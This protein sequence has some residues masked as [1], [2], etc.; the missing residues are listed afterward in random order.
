MLFR[1]RVTLT[2][3]ERPLFKGSPLF[4]S[5]SAEYAQLLRQDS[6]GTQSVDKGL[7]R[8]DVT[9]QLRY[10]FKKWQWFTVN[11]SLAFRETWYSKSQDPTVTDPATNQP[12]LLSTALNRHYFTMT[13]SVVGP[14]FNRIWN[15]PDNGY[16]EKFK[17][18]IEPYTTVM[19]TSDIGDL[20]RIIQIDSTDF[21][22]GG[23]QVAYGIHNPGRR[24]HRVR[25]T[26]GHEVRALA[27]GDMAHRIHHRAVGVVE[28]HDLVSGG[29][30]QGAKYRVDPGRRVVDT[31]R[32]VAARQLLLDRLGQVDLFCP[33]TTDPVA[34]L[35]H[36]DLRRFR[37]GNRRFRNTDQIGRAHV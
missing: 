1:S 3:G 4:F 28:H 36:D 30:S 7:G 24:K 31:D 32:E 2:R 34:R 20:G 23:T 11:S 8:I 15:T 33:V 37:V 27:S 14:V 19:R 26:R 29:E 5:A 6:N 35:G 9:P 21:I 12:A 10:P 18:S 13:A 22:V 16:A 25:H 17:H